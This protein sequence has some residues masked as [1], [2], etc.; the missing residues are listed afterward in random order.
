[1]RINDGIGRMKAGQLSPQEEAMAKTIANG[2]WVYH[3]S[4]L[5][6]LQVDR[7]ISD[8]IFTDAMQ[9]AE[10]VSQGQGVNEWKA[11]LPPGRLRGL[12]FSPPDDEGVLQK[13]FLIFDGK[14]VYATTARDEYF[15]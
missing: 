3:L 8:M 6:V 7:I 13:W 14:Q 2:D 12:E 1:M 11:D 10:M 4:P 9:L 5:G 15:D